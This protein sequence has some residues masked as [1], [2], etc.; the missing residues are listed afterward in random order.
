MRR[1]ARCARIAAAA[2]AGALAVVAAVASAATLKAGTFDPPAPAPELA[3]QASDGGTLTLERFR[4]RVVLLEFGFTS[5]PEV[6][7]TTLATLAAARKRLGAAADGVQVVFVTVDPARDDASRLRAYLRGF[8]PAFLGGTG[9]DAQLA[10]VRAAYGVVARRQPVGDSYTVGH[11]SSVF[12]IDRH[13]RL[14]G[15]FPY[16]TPAADVHHDLQL[17]LA[18]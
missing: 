5:C 9:S 18:E 15:L 10:A 11:S 3:L 1:P 16:G 7:P 2:L 17:L 13:G 12:L 4:G 8:D 6:C 14:R